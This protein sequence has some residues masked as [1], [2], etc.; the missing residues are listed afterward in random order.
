[1][2]SVVG[3]SGNAGQCNYSASKAGMMVWQNL[4]QKNWAQ[5]CRANAIAPGSLLQK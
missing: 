4:L 3:V 1:M 5:G 2:S